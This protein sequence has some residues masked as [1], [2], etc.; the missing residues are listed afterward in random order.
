MDRYFTD[1][2]NHVPEVT[3]VDVWDDDGGSAPIA[4]SVATLVLPVRNLLRLPPR[5]GANVK[6]PSGLRIDAKT[7][8]RHAIAPDQ[9]LE[10]QKLDGQ[11]LRLDPASPEIA[12]MPRLPAR[13]AK[14]AR[15]EVNH[16]PPGEGAEWGHSRKL[17]IRWLLWI[18]LGITSL[19]IVALVLLPLIN[20]SNAA[21]P[22]TVGLVMDQE[23]VIEGLAALNDLTTRQLDAEQI[24]R[25]FAS[26]S[27]VE[28]IL[29]LVRNAPAMEPLIRK[30]SRSAPVSRQWLPPEDTTWSVFDREGLTCGLLAGSLPDFS[31]FNAYLILVH[32]QLYLDWKASTGYGTAT[33]QQL[34]ENQGDPAEIRAMV[35]L[36]EFYTAAFP[37]AEFQSYQLMSPDDS[38][39]IWCYTR[40]GEPAHHALGKLFQVGE[41]LE[42]SLEHQKVTVRLAHGPAGALPNQWLIAEMLHQDWITP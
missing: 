25:A 9:H 1:P 15:N 23:D 2:H 20:Q 34:Q 42:R 12:K 29:P 41:I 21:R 19:V 10:V 31:K 36:S 11:V 16:T 27:I 8:E 33:F 28:E 22:A 40:R 7:P 39:S 17:P 37:E 24:Y 26:T 32:N 5:P 30:A 38:Q 4:A 13:Q 3:P 35:L 18:G 6:K 14:P